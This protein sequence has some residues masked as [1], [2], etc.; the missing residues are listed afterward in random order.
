MTVVELFLG[1]GFFGDEPGSQPTMTL[2]CSFSDFLAV[3]LPY[4]PKKF[5]QTMTLIESGGCW[6][7]MED[8]FLS[9]MVDLLSS[10]FAKV[11]IELGR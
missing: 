1:R 7:V 8:P 5:S 4:I 2:S 6:V 11:G 3:S 10:T 9:Q